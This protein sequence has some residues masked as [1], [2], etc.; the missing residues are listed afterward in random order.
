L[1]T[2]KAKHKPPSKELIASLVLEMISYPER[3]SEDPIDSAIDLVIASILA[4]H[5]ENPLT[6]KSSK[7][8]PVLLYASGLT[9]TIDLYSAKAHTSPT[10]FPI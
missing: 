4:L 9:I 1:I 6:V 7:M 5:N 2:S 8:A 10:V 3:L